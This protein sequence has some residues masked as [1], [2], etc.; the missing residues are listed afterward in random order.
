MSVSVSDLLGKKHSIDR[1]AQTFRSM[2]AAVDE[3]NL[4]LAVS[5]GITVIIQATAAAYKAPAPIIRKAEVLIQAT[6]E[7]IHGAVIRRAALEGFHPWKSRKIKMPKTEEE[8]E[9]DKTIEEME[10]EE[11]TAVKIDIKTLPFRTIKVP[12]AERFKRHGPAEAGFYIP[13]PG[14]PYAFKLLNLIVSLSLVPAESRKKIVEEPDGFTVYGAKASQ[15]VFR[16]MT[17]IYNHFPWVK[18]SLMGMWGLVS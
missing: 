5:R 9:L 11:R 8:I 13:T 10:E 17:M 16:A 6:R 2:K 4:R 7:I 3:G 12:V 14:D 15:D 1:A 18:Q